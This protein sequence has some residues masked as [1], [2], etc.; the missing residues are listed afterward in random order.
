VI[1]LSLLLV[2]ATPAVAQ[3][4]RIYQID[5]EQADAAMLVM[6]NG[7]T[8]LIDSGKN[9]HGA[10]IQA[11][12]K[13]AGVTQIDAFVTSHYHE[14]HFG[15]IDELVDAGVPVLEAYDR[16]D[17]ACCLP[18]AKKKQPTYI[19]YQRTVGEDAIQVRPGHAIN[20]DPLVTITVIAAGGVVVG[21]TTPSDADDENDMSVAL[22]INF[23]GFKAFFG[24]DIH[25][26]T[27]SKI[28]Q[29]DL[30]L[31]VD[32]YKGDHHGSHTSSSVAFMND[33]RPTVI[34]LSNG[35]DAIYKHPRLVSL[36]TYAALVPAT[37]VFQVNKCLRPAPCAN[38]P[39]AQVADRETVDQDGTILTTVDG[40]SNNYTL[41][42]GTTT[43]TFAIKAPTTATP[44]T[45]STPT[46]VIS[47]L[48]PNPVGADEQQESVT[49]QNKGSVAA[50]LVGWTL[51][52]RSGATWSLTGSIAPGQARTFKRNGQAMS[53]NNA[54]DEVVLRDGGDVERDRFAY[55]TST[56]GAVV[57]TGH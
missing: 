30:V 21:E 37:T 36:Q 49:L 9:G 7:K 10:R 34:A 5:V 51:E 22:L 3:T 2:T 52:D 53:L 35:N 39:D 15:G 20:L 40:T 55:T 48:L 44:T 25:A 28:A 54:G 12:M 46:V 38:V 26:H 27:E 17:K 33:L 11:V 1:V 18:A 50:S 13:Q 57:N 16:G 45:P 4:L 23:R 31:D 14:D 47:R 24:G 8:L 32:Y 29:R 19:D 6:P 41:V 56:E 42:F 43:R